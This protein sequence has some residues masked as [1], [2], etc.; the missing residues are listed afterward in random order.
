[1][2]YNIWIQVLE[3][4]YGQVRAGA[5]GQPE[6]EDAVIGRNPPGPMDLSLAKSPLRSSPW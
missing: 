4:C 5:R 6:S 3:D 2:S 1:M